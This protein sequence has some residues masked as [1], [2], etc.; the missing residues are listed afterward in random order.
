MFLIRGSFNSLFLIIVVLISC[1]QPDPA[2]APATD[3]GFTTAMEL[4]NSQPDSAF[5][6]FNEIAT[7][8]A[9]SLEIASALNYM[10]IIQHNAGDYF[11]SIETLLAALGYL[12]EESEEKRPYYQA[13]YNLLGSNNLTLGNYVDAIL[14][15]QQT[16]DLTT[17]RNFKNIALNNLAMAYQKMGDN[18]KAIELF[19]ILLKDTVSNPVNQA[20]VQSNLAR[21]RWLQNKSFNLLPD[22]WAALQIRTAEKDQWGLNASYSHLADYYSGRRPDSALF[23][24]SRMYAVAT[25]LNSV[26]DQLEALKKLIPLASTDKVKGFVAEYM[27]L[28]DSLQAARNTARNQ[29]A[30]IR[31]EAAKS[32]AEN[33]ELLNTNAEKESLLFR[34]QL[35]GGALV[36]ALLGLFIFG[37]NRQRKRKKQL[38]LQF[39][40]SLR[41][42]QL[43]TSQKVHD[44]VANGLYRIMTSIEHNPDLDKAALLDDV[45]YL[46]EKSR[47]I[48]YDEEE[49]REPMTGYH[50]KISA[51]INNFGSGSTKIM[52]AGN[53]PDLW[54]SIGQRLK[55]EVEPI[56]QELLV[57]MDK[58]SKASNVLVKF[59]RTD[60]VLKINYTD[61][62]VG[63]PARLKF[64]NGLRNTENRIIG[65]N[66]WLNFK[67]NPLNGLKIQIHL[68]VE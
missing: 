42:Q 48:S 38:Q 68:P 37:M 47:D 2:Q 46:Y 23:Y 26:D 33:L 19:S 53:D 62:G 24:A 12:K 8:S 3:A 16:A 32:K 39:E 49:L 29:F 7:Q 27:H 30:L 14:Y 52:V 21:T 59:E 17:D 10:A 22:Y 44:V 50:Q 65:L 66:G 61:N 5:Y 35:I 56:L 51:L 9:D 60:R 43:K 20:R 25:D 34:Q 18:D 58:H 41:E 28:S 4:L 45:E 67:N 40:Q 11:G 36:L 15:Y 55:S 13:V 63:L 6:Y 57:N 54:K 31:Y 64:G 1:K